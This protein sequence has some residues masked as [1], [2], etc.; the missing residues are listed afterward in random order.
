VWARLADTAAR[1]EWNHDY[2]LRRI[3]V[4]WLQL[5]L[6]A[7]SCAEGSEGILFRG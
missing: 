3:R 1:N 2:G 7:S 5:S 6:C 4:A